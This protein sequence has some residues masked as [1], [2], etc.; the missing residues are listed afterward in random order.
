MITETWYV[1]ILLPPPLIIAPKYDEIPEE[2]IISDYRNRESE[3]EQGLVYHGDK[4]VVEPED[5]VMNI[6][7]RQLL[8]N[9]NKLNP[10]RII[11]GAPPPLKEGL[12]R[13]KTVPARLIQ[14]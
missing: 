13:F 8:L 11:I 4:V 12:T 7:L 5:T 10:H 14:F 2:N 6:K 9:Q 3:R 1:T